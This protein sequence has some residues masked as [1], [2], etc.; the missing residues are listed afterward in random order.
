MKPRISKR[1]LGIALAAMAM[2]IGMATGCGT[3][4]PAATDPGASQANSSAGSNSKINVVAAENFYGE[5]AQAVGGDRRAGPMRDLAV[6]RRGQWQY[7][8]DQ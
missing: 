5:V 1:K 6:M 4:T 2:A 8:D 7:R 3:A